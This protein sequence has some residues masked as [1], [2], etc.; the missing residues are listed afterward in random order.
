M[1]DVKETKELIKGILEVVKVSA[2]VFKDGFQAQDIVDGYMKLAADPVKKAALEAALA[3]VGEV[4][5]E[6]KDVSLAEGVEIL[7]VVAQELPALLEAFKK[8]A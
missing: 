6:L 4:P 5:E 2:E 7:V 3:N 1:Q 8:K